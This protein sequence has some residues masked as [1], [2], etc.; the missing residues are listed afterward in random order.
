MKS[1]SFKIFGVLILVFLCQLA[2]AKLQ[3]KPKHCP[4]VS[5]IKSGLLS[6][7]D[8]SCADGTYTTG[9]SSKYGTEKPWVFLIR[10]ISA[11]GKEDAM[12][13]GL[14]FLRSVS[15]TPEPQ[16]DPSYGSW[17]CR[18]QL[19]VRDLVAEAVVMED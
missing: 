17:T 11:T 2:F 6:F 19:T 10:H 7:V 9:Q 8:Y 3:E 14:I 15:G 4:E 12:K 1:L 13:K 5:F 18:Y 16:F